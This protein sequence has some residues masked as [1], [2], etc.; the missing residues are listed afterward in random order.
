MHVFM[1][2]WLHNYPFMYLSYI[3]MIRNVF[4]GTLTTKVSKLVW[5]CES[6]SSSCRGLVQ[7][8]S[9]TMVRYKPLSDDLRRV[10][11]HMHHK[12]NLD[13]KDIQRQTNLHQRTIE[14]VLKLYWET[15]GIAACKKKVIRD[16]RLGTH[17]ADVRD[18]TCF[19]YLL[20]TEELI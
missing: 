11:V 17:D 20:P 2:E 15:G 12:R 1:D 9:N 19:D 7:L 10:I 16:G 14:K 5:T 3:V 13:S 6:C 18:Y 4:H 8:A